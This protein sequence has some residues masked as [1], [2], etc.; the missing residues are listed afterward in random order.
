MSGGDKVSSLALGWLRPLISAAALQQG[1]GL[2]G[3]C[4]GPEAPRHREAALAALA[5][6][7]PTLATTACQMASHE[8]PS[9]V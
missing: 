3:S 5:A 7:S 1:T 8:R 9:S 2:L 4:D 6:L